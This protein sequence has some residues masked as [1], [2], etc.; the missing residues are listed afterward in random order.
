MQGDYRR[1]KRNRGVLAKCTAKLQRR[2]LATMFGA[3]AA[4][5]YAERRYKVAIKRCLGKIARREVLEAFVDWGVATVEAKVTRHKLEKAMKRMANG[6]RDSSLRLP[7]ARPPR[8][9]AACCPNARETL[10]RGKKLT[11]SC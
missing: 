2:E 11:H 7:R 8:A 6:A 4:D 9:R 5:S 10:C 1:E 3:W